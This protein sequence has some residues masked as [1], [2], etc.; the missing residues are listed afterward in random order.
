MLSNVH[1][2]AASSSAPG[3][4]LSS[5]SLVRGEAASTASRIGPSSS[6]KVALL[7]RTP[8]TPSGKRS[9][10]LTRHASTMEEVFHRS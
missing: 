4:V 7:L 1:T 10:F 8:A 2:L 9:N 3:L 6:T 5:S